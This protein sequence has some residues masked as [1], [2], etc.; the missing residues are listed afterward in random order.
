MSGSL[1]SR[2]AAMIDAAISET[3]CHTFLF[4]HRLWSVPVPRALWLAHV[5]P[6]ICDR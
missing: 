2:T 3:I 5:S 1:A 6:L 4:Y